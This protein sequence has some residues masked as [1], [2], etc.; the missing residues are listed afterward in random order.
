MILHQN[1][2]ISFSCRSDSNYCKKGSVS[3]F[4]L[5]SCGSTDQ[6]NSKT[7][8]CLLGQVG[9]SKDISLVAGSYDVELTS[10]HET[11]QKSAI[12]IGTGA[13]Y[14]IPVFSNHNET[15]F[16]FIQDINTNTIS[17]LW[18]FPQFIVMTIAEVFVSITGLEFAYSQAPNS[19]KSVLQSFWLLTTALGNIIV[20]ILAEGR[21]LPSQ[22]GEYYLLAGIVAACGV[23]YFLLSYFYYEYADANEFND[24][25]YPDEMKVVK[26]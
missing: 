4:A 6:V 16:A 5:A 21:F 20:I 8:D 13:A 19:M 2:T 14:T 12:E 23:V 15:D 7:H 24:F 1:I 10:E 3:T 25:D 11:I 22:V 17:I 26:S 9:G 18:C